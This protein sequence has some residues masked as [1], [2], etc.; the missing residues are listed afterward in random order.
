[1]RSLQTPEIPEYIRNLVPYVPGKPIEE[2]Q[3][4]LKLKRVI[5]LASNEN[6][7]GPSPKAVQAIQK[8]MKELHRYPDASGYRLKQRL[9]S[10][11]QVAPQSIVLGNGSNDVIDLLIRSFC[12]SGDAI[13]TSQAAFVAYR[14]CAQIQGVKSIESPL[15]KDLRFDLPEM[16]KLVRKNPEVKMVFIANPNN[17]TGTYVTTAEVRTF[18]EGMMKIRGGSIPVVIDSA[19]AEFVTAKDLPDPLQLAKEFPNLVIL[20][21]FSKVYGLGGLRV[22]YGIA[23]PELVATLEK[24]RQP[25]NL[26]SLAL[27]GAEAA[28][29]DRAFVAKALKTNRLGMKYWEQQLDKLKIPYWKSQGNFLLIDVARGLGRLGG[30]VYL[31][32]LKQGVIFRPVANYGLHQCLRI[33][34]GTMEENRFAVKAL[35]RVMRR[36]TPLASSKKRG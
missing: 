21:T 31:D 29:S 3:R 10:H 24:V 33:S 8:A 13:V 2:T 20:R 1:M 7:L 36:I 17:P 30:E 19:Y 12:V 5:K 15:T 16:L 26:N 14:I 11:L 27:A 23:Q 18:L 32:C 4:E 35:T 9:A 28:L 25:F 34:V 22:G 6:P